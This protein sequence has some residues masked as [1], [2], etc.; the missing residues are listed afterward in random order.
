M[1]TTILRY[2]HALEDLREAQR[3]MVKK[4]DDFRALHFD[5]VADDLEALADKIDAALDRLMENSEAENPQGWNAERRI[6]DIMSTMLEK[7]I[8]DDE[9]AKQ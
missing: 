8:E 9:R 2:F 5:G 4:S 7:S 1:T 3:A 6:D